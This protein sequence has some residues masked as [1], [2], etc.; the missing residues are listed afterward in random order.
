MRGRLESARLALARATATIGRHWPAERAHVIDVS[1]IT[2]ELDAIGARLDAM[3]TETAAQR[4]SMA[5]RDVERRAAMRGTAADTAHMS[6]SGRELE[7]RRRAIGAAET[8]T[9][10][11]VNPLTV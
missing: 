6:V 4:A 9:R 2:A 1:T 7:R 10:T 3:A 11:T 5:D 8:E